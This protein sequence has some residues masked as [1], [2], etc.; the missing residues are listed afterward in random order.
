MDPQRHRDL[1]ASIVFALAIGL[2]AVGAIAGWQG[3][4]PLQEK[5]DRAPWPTWA[6]TADSLEA[7]PRRLDAWWN[8]HF[9]FRNALVRAH[10]VVRV[11]G[12]GLDPPAVPGFTGADDLDPSQRRKARVGRDGWLFLGRHFM[13]PDY[14][15]RRPLEPAV[16]R[17]W[18]LALETRRDWLAQRGIRYL[19]VLVPDKHTIYP[20][21]LPPDLRASSPHSR[22]DELLEH[23]DRESDL[24]VVDLRPAL[25]AAKI[26]EAVY[27]PID[28]HWNDPGVYAGYRAVMKELRAWYPGLR[29]WPRHDFSEEPIPPP[30]DLAALLGLDG[31]L[32][33]PVV[34][35]TPRRARATLLQ[36]RPDRRFERLTTI[37][38]GPNWT[39][40]VNLAH[41]TCG[42]PHS[43]GGT[44][45]SG[46][47][48][49]P[50]LGRMWRAR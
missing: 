16:R 30:H 2:P 29:A 17:R 21:H 36:T 20:E 23:L 42:F 22:T 39:S 33:D 11:L 15:N 9:G 32:G 49:N 6:W 50:A 24:T 38:R 27:T 25:R 1:L 41:E 5:R 10:A 45:E 37:Y 4:L 43:D 44:R 48:G 14:P 35:L 26:R 18:Q 7:Y 46:D 12:L 31:I 3:A 13:G 34:G 47:E 28:S 40:L 19:I 8:D